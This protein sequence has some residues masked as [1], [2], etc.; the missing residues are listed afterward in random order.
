ML[1]WSPVATRRSLLQASAIRTMLTSLLNNAVAGSA[2][3]S[4]KLASFTYDGAT[5]FE[6][7]ILLV[8]PTGTTAD[9]MDADAADTTKV[10]SAL[11]KTIKEDPT[12]KGSV[13]LTSITVEQVIETL[14]TAAARSF[15]DRDTLLKIQVAAASVVDFQSGLEAYIG[16]SVGSTSGS[17]PGAVVRELVE[18]MDAVGELAN[19]GTAVSFQQFNRTKSEFG[20]TMRLTFPGLIEV[21]G[22]EVQLTNTTGDE[23]ARAFLFIAQADLGKTARRSLLTKNKVFVDS[24]TS[25][26][27]ASVTG[28]VMDG[29][30]Y[31]GLEA[32]G[33]SGAAAVRA[34]VSGIVLS[35]AAI[36]ALI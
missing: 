30:E 18:I 3:T 19:N 21:D 6:I 20:I 23:K 5:G 27:Y 14:F 7:E 34:W 13:D 1:P 28:C 32:D 35:I 33:F 4:A 17:T 11:E 2:A 25:A 36:M 26:G 8:Y 12:F 15:N 31:K 16:G 29:A 9:A 22:K 24:C 10:A